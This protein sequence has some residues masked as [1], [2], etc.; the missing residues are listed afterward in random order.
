M[1][2]LLVAFIV[3]PPSFYATDLD[4]WFFPPINKRLSTGEGCGA[5]SVLYS[6]HRTYTGSIQRGGKGQINTKTPPLPKVYRKLTFSAHY[7]IILTTT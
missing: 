1:D 5:K 7:S 6:A 2:G 3:P 4:A